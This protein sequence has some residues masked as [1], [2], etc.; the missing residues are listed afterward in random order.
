MCI[1]KSAASYPLLAPL[2]PRLDSVLRL[3]ED[4][5][6]SLSFKKRAILDSKFS[7][8]AQV[9]IIRSTLTLSWTLRITAS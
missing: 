5:R 1:N 6:S 7:L 2:P 3:R 4:N 9:F 8:G